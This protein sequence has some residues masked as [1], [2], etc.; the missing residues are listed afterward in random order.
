MII[1]WQHHFS[2]K[3]IFNR[4]GGKSGQPVIKN[5]K[6]GQRLY[7]EIYQIDKHLEFMDAAGIDMAVFSTTRD[8]IEECK[9]TDDL[10]VK[11]MKEHSSRVVCLAPC[12]PAHGKEAFDE[13]DRAINILG[14][15]GVT[16]SPQNDGIPLDSRKLWPFYEKAS[17][18]RIPIFV[19]VTPVPVGYDAL[20]AP[21]NLNVTLTR[22]FDIASNTIRLILGGVLAEFPD[23]TFVMS[24]M[25][26]GISSILE[27]VERY[28]DAWGDSFWTELGGTPPFDKP[29]KEHF[30]R[31]F[32][33]IYFDMAG[34]EGG[35]N[36]VKC[37]LTAIRPEKL[38]FATDYPYNFT[39]DPQG[40]KEYIGN[41][42]KL[43]LP[44]DLTES[45]LGNTAAELLSL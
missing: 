4:L 26:G 36:G 3:E 30:R 8:S 24:H 42:R 40:V 39:N 45:I 18:W 19:H 27:R 14:L 6:V 22:E 10:Y 12:M 2:S 7:E 16:I 5:G 38:M 33:R 23:L 29:Y 32:D 35:M 43:D 9:L 21:Y 31:Y 1:D 41:I 11:V 34:L 37:A 20:D 25:G 17:Q 28:V 15:K 13:L 44:S